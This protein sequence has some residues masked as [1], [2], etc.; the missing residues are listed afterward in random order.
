MSFMWLTEFPSDVSDTTYRAY[1][2]SFC[3]QKSLL[4]V[5]D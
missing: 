1:I 2:V 5:S 4:F 3:E